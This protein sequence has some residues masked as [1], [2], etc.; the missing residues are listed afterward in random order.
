MTL[1][2][3]IRVLRS[4]NYEVRFRQNQWCIFTSRE[5]ML[6]DRAIVR[7]KKFDDAVKEAIKSGQQP[8]SSEWTVKNVGSRLQ[9]KAEGLKARGQDR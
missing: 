9:P 8:V 4:V 5:D 1:P 6:M 7:N 3:A 2:D